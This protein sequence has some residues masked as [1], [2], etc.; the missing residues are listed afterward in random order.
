LLTVVFF[1]AAKRKTMASMQRRLGPNIV[2]LLQRLG[3]D[4]NLKRFFTII[5]SS[6]NWINYIN[7]RL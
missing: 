4:F 1:T 3:G 7:H 2:G 5:S 6:Y